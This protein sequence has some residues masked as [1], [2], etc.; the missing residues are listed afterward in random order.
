MLRNV[1]I[2]VDG[3]F[4]L[5]GH[6]RYFNLAK[7]AEETANDLTIHCLKHIDKKSERLYRIFFYDCAPLCKKIHHPISN[8]LI[9]LSKTDTAIFRHELHRQIKKKRNFALR[10]GFLD[11]NN[12]RWKIKAPDQEKQFIAGKIKQLEE[13]DLVYHAQQKAVDM[14]LGLDIATLAYKKLVNKIV[15]ISGDSD[16]VPVAKFA[17]REGM[18]FILDAMHA[19]IKDNLQEHIDGLNTTLPTR[20]KKTPQS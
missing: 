10:L 1:A 19:K 4:Y 13:S 18:E 20:T 9:D 6:A 8:K 3:G 16:F 12:A 5:K 17:R 2:L 15:L 11:E 14:K 7:N